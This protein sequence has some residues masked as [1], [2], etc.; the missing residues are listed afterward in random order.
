MLLVTSLRH[1]VGPI[2]W[3]E[4][5]V[6]PS[7]VA[8]LGVVAIATGALLRSLRALPL[9]AAGLA[10]VDVW[11]TYT[12]FASGA[13]RSG[14]SAWFA[15]FVP[16]PTTI[17][18][19]S[20]L[21]RPAGAHVA[22]V[23]GL[24][25]SVAALLMLRERRTRTSVMI[26]MACVGVLVGSVPIQIIGSTGLTADDAERQAASLAT[27]QAALSCVVRRDVRYCA[28]P[29]YESWIPVWTAPVEGVLRLA[30]T[31]DAGFAVVQQPEL[32]RL[33]EDVVSS[34]PAHMLVRSSSGEEW[35]YDG[36]L[37]PGFSWT[38]RPFE[39]SSELALA[40]DAASRVVGLHPGPRVEGRFF[41]TCTMAGQARAITVAWLAGQATAASRASLRG[42]IE[43]EPWGVTSGEAG[44]ASL[45]AVQ[46]LFG[47]LGQTYVNWDKREINYGAQ[48]MQRPEEE[49][50]AVLAANW[51][52]LTSPRTPTSKALELLDLRELRTPDQLIEDAAL[53]PIQAEALRAR[54]RVETDSETSTQPCR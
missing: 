29:G 2:V 41:A 48:L 20:L 16:P 35:R 30:P 28:F 22:Y 47:G 3:A 44:G 43:S 51:R 42:V 13:V 52:L 15:L 8:L 9:V 11:L 49:V 40:V 1:A 19:P 18:P 21:S 12:G 24:T 5:L 38:L 32:E 6:G 50:R 26:A 53:A 33:E 34:L 10:I 36:N 54:L 39:R 7:L 17:L 14:P 4:L 37:H 45:S 25:A 23:L 46:S 31:S 27:G